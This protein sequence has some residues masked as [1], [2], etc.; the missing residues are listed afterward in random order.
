MARKPNYDFERR[1]REIEKKE[2]KVAKA[3][4]RRDQ[5]GHEAM[6]ETGGVERDAAKADAP[7][8]KD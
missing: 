4:A 7:I 3:E 2:K 6:P 1:Q 5:R 8:V